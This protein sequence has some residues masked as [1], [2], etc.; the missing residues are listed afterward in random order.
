MMQFP[1]QQSLT[2]LMALALI[3]ILDHP[4]TV[5]KAPRLIENGGG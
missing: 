1:D 5:T 4:H 3:D 2:L